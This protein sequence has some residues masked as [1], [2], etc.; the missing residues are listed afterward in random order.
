MNDDPRTWLVTCDRRE[1][2]PF[3]FGVIGNP[4]PNFCVWCG[5]PLA[6][7]GSTTSDGHTVQLVS[8]DEQPVGAA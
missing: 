5:K 1:V 2:F 8:D 7:A 4:R 6:L 3:P